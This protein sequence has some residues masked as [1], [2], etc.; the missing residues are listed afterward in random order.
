MTRAAAVYAEALY[1]LAKDEA[2]GTRIFDEIKALDK[3]F[4]AEKDFLR[5]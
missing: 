1:D 3:A 4:E 5:R 2:L